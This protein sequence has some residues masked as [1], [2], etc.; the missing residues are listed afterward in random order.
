R[1]HTRLQGDWSSDVCS[2]D[3]VA[4]ERFRYGVLAALDARMAEPRQ[5]HW[6]SF[7][8]EYRV[9][10]PQA[11]ESGDVAQYTMNLKIHLVESLLHVRSE[12]RRVG[13]ECGSRM[14]MYD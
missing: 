11:A 14:S 4:L 1:R 3:L 8:F 10:Y 13:K 2:S 5:R 7:T 12:E 6:I 9:Q